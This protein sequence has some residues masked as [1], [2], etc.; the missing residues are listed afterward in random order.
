LN[1]TIKRFILPKVTKQYLFRI[2]MVAVLAYIFFSFICLPFRIS[3]HSMNPT[4]QNGQ[5]NL[6][7]RLQYILSKPERH[8]VVAIRLAGKKI[9]LLKRVVALEGETVEIKNGILFV[10]QTKID[11]PY[12]RRPSDWNL[13][14]RRVDPGHVYVIGDNRS[15]PMHVHQFGQTQLNR[16]IG[17]PLW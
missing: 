5:I 7:F 4:Y 6:C 10:N 14:L 17:A 1:T 9:V 3:G 11:E 16:I 12:V 13:A 2:L 8:D 15:V